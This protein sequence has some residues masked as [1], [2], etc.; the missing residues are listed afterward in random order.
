MLALVVEYHMLVRLPSGSQTAGLVWVPNLSGVLMGTA[1]QLNDDDI[2]F[3]V[4]L[5]KN[6]SQPLTTQQLIQALRS[7]G[8]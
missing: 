4:S 6:S 8:R 7:R 1:I 5:L 3:L 2:A